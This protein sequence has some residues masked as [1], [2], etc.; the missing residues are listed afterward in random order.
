MFISVFYVLADVNYKDVSLLNRA[1]NF[2]S[3][4]GNNVYRTFNEFDK[5]KQWDVLVVGS[6]HAYRGYS[7]AIFE[8]SGYEMYN[9]GSS[10]QSI[11]ETYFIVEDLE[12]QP[13]LLIIDLHVGSFESDG[14][15][16]ASNLI[17]N[18]PS[19]DLAKGI[20]FSEFN[21]ML[22]SAYSKRVLENDKLPVFLDSEKDREAFYKGFVGSNDSVKNEIDYSELGKEFSPNEFSFEYLAKLIK[23]AEERKIEMVFVTHPV[24]K[25]F[26]KKEMNDF[27]KEVKKV[28]SDHN[29]KW[30]NFAFSNSDKF[31]SQTDFFDSNHLNLNGVKKF[32][33]LLLSRLKKLNKID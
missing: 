1:N 30:L 19:D 20:A 31:N 2:Y 3:V 21:W 25:E 6:S 29:F 27:S 12:V 9:L 11:R 8:A 18:V 28:L 10:G 32:N 22:F 33:A 5:S 16:S 13:K 4:K 15:E 14:T 17:A 26:E 24:P 23:I 7:P